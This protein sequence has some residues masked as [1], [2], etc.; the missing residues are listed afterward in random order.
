LPHFAGAKEETAMSLNNFPAGW[1][2]DRVRRALAHYEG[3]TE[4]DVLLEDEAGI[5]PSE[6]VMNVPHDLVAKVRE[7]I[8]K[9]QS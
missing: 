2:E 9:R 5:E 1:D 4:E 6:T 7:L 8:A 3:P